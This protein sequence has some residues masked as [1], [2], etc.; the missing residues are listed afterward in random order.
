MNKYKQLVTDNLIGDCFRTCIATLLQLPPEVLPNDFSPNWSTNWDIYL[1]QFGLGLSPNNN[2]SQP[3]W[4]STPWIASVKSLNYKD[5]THAILM[6]KTSI[7]LHDPSTK[8]QY[9]TGTDLFGKDVVM[10]GCHILVTD[11]TKLH[12]LDEYRKRITP[13]NG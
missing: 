13:N 6:H 10:S 7:V 1:E 11:I 4:L 12:V 9:K 2:R 8:K 5:G 3:I